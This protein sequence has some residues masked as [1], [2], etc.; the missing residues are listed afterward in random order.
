MFGYEVP[1][2]PKSSIVVKSPDAE[3][4]RASGIYLSRTYALTAKRHAVT[5]DWWV[6]DHL[7]A[8]RPSVAR[9]VM[10]PTV[11][12][13]GLGDGEGDGDAWRTAYRAKTPEKAEPKL[14]NLWKKAE[15]VMARAPQDRVGF[16]KRRLALAIR[17]GRWLQVLEGKVARRRR[18]E[19]RL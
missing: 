4:L 12:P 3:L 19:G 7:F 10:D 5:G 15:Y 14:H 8:G 6:H 17:R 1:I 18:A 9:S 11:V 2:P 13:V 16:A